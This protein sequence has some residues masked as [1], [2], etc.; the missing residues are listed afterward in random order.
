[1]T[2]HEGGII[3]IIIGS[4]STANLRN[5]WQACAN[6]APIINAILLQVIIETKR[7]H[8]SCG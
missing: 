7:R 1:M 5:P 8:P 6:P 2:P 3:I 4:G